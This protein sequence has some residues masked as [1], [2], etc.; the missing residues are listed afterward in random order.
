MARLGTWLTLLAA[1]ACSACRPDQ[2]AEYDW[3][4]G[5]TDPEPAA[6]LLA[7]PPA[8]PTRQSVPHPITLLLPKE[9]H[10]DAFTGTRTFDRAGGVRGIDV[11]IKATDHYGTVT[12]AFGVFRFELYTVVS[13]NANRR[14][15]LVSRWNV[16]LSNP[17]VNVKHWEDIPPC[18]KFRLK[19]SRPIPV[20]Q[21]FMLAVVFS[22]P[23]TERK[24]HERVFV[25]GE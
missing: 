12:K 10:I 2:S 23:F 17:K 18:Y 21:Q 6:A 11:R 5:A 8:A 15:K 19:W 7:P 3:G 4:A 16:D 13:N 1:L 9:V 24:F 14:G 20:G 25:A 22:S